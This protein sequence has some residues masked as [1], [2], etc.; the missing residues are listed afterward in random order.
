MKGYF[1]RQLLADRKI[2]VNDIAHGLGV[3]QAAVSRVIHGQ[4]R[5]T[6]VQGAI[7][8][9]IGKPVEEVFPENPETKEAA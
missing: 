7:A 6:R 4:T 5:S 9:A 1:I 8:E 3:S 2:K